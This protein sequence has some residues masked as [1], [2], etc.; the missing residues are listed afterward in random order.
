MKKTFRLKLLELCKT[1]AKRANLE[2]F[3][4]RVILA[5]HDRV[6]DSGKATTSRRNFK[7]PSLQTKK[8]TNEG[9]S[10]NMGF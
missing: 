3:N 5:G 2:I 4:F 7:A 1:K 6:N 10:E 8:I 9:P